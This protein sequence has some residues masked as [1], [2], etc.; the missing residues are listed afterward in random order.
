MNALQELTML[1]Q[2]TGEAVRSRN[3]WHG[4]RR[5]DDGNF[6]IVNWAHRN[7]RYVSYQ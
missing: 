1:G 4:S 2:L 5:K 6:D 7:A 3:P